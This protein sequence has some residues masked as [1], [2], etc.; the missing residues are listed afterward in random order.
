ML[1][2]CFSEDLEL[3]VWQSLETEVMGKKAK[4][5]HLPNAELK[6]VPVVH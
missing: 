6:E 3:F 4:P 2:S 1:F 5:A